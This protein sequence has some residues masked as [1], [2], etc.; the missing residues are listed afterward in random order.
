MLLFCPACGNVLVAE[1]GARCH[2]FACTTCPYVRNVTRKVGVR[3]GRGG[4]SLAHALASPASA[5][6]LPALPG[7]E[8]A[9]PEAEGSGRR[10][11]RGRRMGE[12]RFDR[13]AL[14]QVRPPARLLHAA[15][16]ALGRRAHDHLLQVLQRPVR[17]PLAGLSGPT[18]EG[19]RESL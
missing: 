15:A 1:E 5:H 3:E 14:P 17:P 2:R 19:S 16:D 10:A 12:R 18:E 4:F 11:G 6:P 8:P 13:R 7:D 9:L